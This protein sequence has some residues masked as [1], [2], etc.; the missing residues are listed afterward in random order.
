M[1]VLTSLSEKEKAKVTS[2]LQTSSVEFKRMED[3]FNQ[4]RFKRKWVQSTT[5]SSGMGQKTRCL[6]SLMHTANKSKICNSFSMHYNASFP[7]LTSMDRE[8]D[9]TLLESSLSSQLVGE[10][11]R[12]DEECNADAMYRT[13]D[14]SCNNLVNPKQG[15]TA[16]PIPRLMDNAYSDG[17]FP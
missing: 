3:T 12:M 4:K 9:L 11:L 8:T 10:V 13:M 6:V 14:G 5:E 1:S 15:A 7:A 17:K 2:A 16:T